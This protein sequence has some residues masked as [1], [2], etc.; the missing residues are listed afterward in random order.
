M[1]GYKS[2]K[3]FGATWRE[4]QG[5]L[6]LLSSPL[7]LN[8]FAEQDARE[9]RRKTGSHFLRWESDFDSI[10][11][12]SWWHVIRDEKIEIEKL[13]SSTRSK[14][15]RG[16]KKF[17]CTI[18]TKDEVLAEGYS[19][20]CSA[21]SR[22][23]T[24]EKQFDREGFFD[25]LLSLPPGTEFWGVRDRDTGSLV[26]FSENF[27]DDDICFINTIWF[28]PQ[29]LKRYASYQLFFEMI[30]HYM[31]FKSFRYISD[32]ARSISHATSIHDYLISKFGFRKA[33]ANLN[34]SYSLW[35]SVLLPPA[36]FFRKIV[37]SIPLGFF[38]KVSII[39]QQEEIRR[40]CSRCK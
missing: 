9:L 14:V 26:A 20:Y 2:I 10:K 32:G 38:R 31:N 23:D 33:Y 39:L 24:H 3:A 25:S 6:L 18:I 4:H 5:A 17:Q 16:A 22:Y 35:L 19:V 13:S 40:A 8:H 27:V 21:F 28:S 11:S 36:Y 15:R 1:I 37:N 12:G 7:S 30:N 34:V 29:S